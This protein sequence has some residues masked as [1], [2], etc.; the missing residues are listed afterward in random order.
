MTLRL[1]EIMVQFCSCEQGPM[2]IRKLMHVVCIVYLS[3]CDPPNRVQCDGGAYVAAQWLQGR[4]CFQWE[5]GGV[6]LSM[7]IW[8]YP[9]IFVHFDSSYIALYSVR[10][11]SSKQG[12]GNFRES[13]QIYNLLESDHHQSDQ[14]IDECNAAKCSR[15][16]RRKGSGLLV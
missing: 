7:D 14:L 16:Y 15:I 2:H 13:N 6:S 10:R 4:R 12:P 8:H 3:A 1:L 5:P 11:G 9:G